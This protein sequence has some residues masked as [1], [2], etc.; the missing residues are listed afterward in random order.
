MLAVVKSGSKQYRVRKG[1]LLRVEKIAGDVGQTVT[2]EQVLLVGEGASA[3]VGTPLV[4]GAKVTAEIVAQGRARKVTSFKYKPSAR[5]SRVR[6]GHRQPYT[7]LRIVG[8]EE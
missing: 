2:L 4:Q 3:R 7:E 6:H 1:E 5:S 8:I